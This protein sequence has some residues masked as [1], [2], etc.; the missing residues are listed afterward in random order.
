MPPLPKNKNLFR[1][2]LLISV[3]L[4]IFFGASTQ[5]A[6]AATYYVDFDGGLDAN[7]GLDISTPW[8]HAPGDSNATGNAS[9]TLVPGDTVLLKGGVHYKGSITVNASGTSGNP[10]TYKGDG[11]GTGKAIIDGSE[12]VTG[13]TACAD[14]P[15]CGNNSNWQHIYHANIPSIPSFLAST[16]E[17]RINVIQDGLP[18]TTAQIPESTSRYYQETSTYYSVAPSNVTTTTITDSRLAALGGA[19]LVGSY[20]YIWRSPNDISFVKISA[21]DSGTNTITFPTTTVYTTKNTLY[22]IANYMGDTVFNQ[23][24]QYYF[25]PTPNG[26]GT[27]DLYVWPLGD[28]DLTTTGE[29]TTSVRSLGISINAKDYVT[30]EGFLIEKQAGDSI[31]EAIGIYQNNSSRATNVLI[32]NNELTLS[33][34]TDYGSIFFQW[35]DTATISNNYVHDTLGNMRGIQAGNATQITISGNQVSNISR[36]GIYFGNADNSE[37]SGNTV[38]DIFSSHGNG[39]TVYQGSDDIDVYNNVVRNSNIN[40]TM[41]AS[42]NVRSYNNILDG[43]NVTSYVVAD[44]GSMSGANT[45]MN[46]TIVNS[47]SNNALQIAGGGTSSWIIE[48]NIIDGGKVTYT[49]AG[50]TYANNIYT[51]LSHFQDSRYGWAL[52]SG[53]SVVTNQDTIFQSPSSNDYRLLSGS[54]AIDTG[55][56]LSSYLTTD[57]Y[58]TSRPQGTSFDIGAHEFGTLVGDTTAPILSAGSPSGILASGTT[59]TSLS[60][61]TNENASCKYSTTPG[62]TYSSMSTFA[63]SGTTTHST[64]LSGLTDGVTYNYYVK[65]QDTSSNTNT[66]DYLITFSIGSDTIPPI[67]SGVFESGITTTSAII[68]WTTNEASDSQVQYSTILDDYSD[69]STLNAALVTTHSETLTGLALNTTYYYKVVSLD[70]AGNRS[71]SAAGTF[72]TLAVN[73]TTAPVISAVSASAGTTTATISWTTDEVATPL[74]NYGTTTSYGTSENSSTFTLSP[75]LTLTGLSPSTTYH[76][77]LVAT[78]PS[79]NVTTSVDYTFTTEADTEVAPAVDATLDV[80]TVRLQFMDDAFRLMRNMKPKVVGETVTLKGDANDFSGGTVKIRVDGDTLGTTDI[81]SDGKWQ[82]KVSFKNSGKTDVSFVYEI[83]GDEKTRKYPVKVDRKDP[84]IDSIPKLLNKRIGSRVYWS[85]T[86]NDEI[87]TYKYEFNGKKVKT[88]K[89]EFFIPRGTTPGTYP[90]VIRA[91]DKAGNADRRDTTIRVNP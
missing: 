67:I 14:A 7:D 37:I 43:Y 77:Q 1:L 86:D 88:G 69:A 64:S 84:E 15:S 23:E 71:E 48:N 39:I 52:A 57:L 80:G 56:D 59:S 53:E 74:V 62:A 33:N 8:K 82:K 70:A 5:T 19:S 66:S 21:Y 35:G 46:N 47:N 2:P 87:D 55:L 26:G 78:D 41:E 30:I 31:G 10:I 72:T 32:N 54:P 29:I 83:N 28:I 40:Y 38:T 42:S 17:I 27:Y 11:W 20:V 9:R 90:L 75:A 4:I 16:P 49:G 12:P 68:R 34:G 89:G 22:A 76:Y 79:D 3:V 60:L 61:T 36:T 65:C 85:A 63:T 50:V 81:K 44:W 6:L 18:I 13:W 58:G 25:N 91:Y 73:D 24:G 51:G 45:F